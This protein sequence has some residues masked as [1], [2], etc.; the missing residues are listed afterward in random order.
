MFTGIVQGL[1]QVLSSTESSGICR[2]RIA[3]P[4][5]REMGLETGASVSI[6]GVCLTC[7]GLDE[8]GVSFDVIAET[9]RLTNLGPLKEG[10]R[11]NVERAAR[12][13]DE[14]GGHMLS[15]HIHGVATVTDLKAQSDNLTV[16]WDV[17]NALQKYVMPKGYVA[18]NGCSLTVGEHHL[19]AQFSVYL[20]PETRRLTTFGRVR[21]G[22][23][24]NLE[25]DSQTQVIVE[26]VER[27]LD[28]R[29]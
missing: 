18:L 28:C 14:I 4:E 12:F 1:G 25:V 11:V 22:D 10:D 5:G 24:L 3:L 21:I 29:S 23:S 26:T 6:N 2:L 9:L 27:V 16:I 20:I 19:G 7:V 17:P 13:G 8:M 15:G